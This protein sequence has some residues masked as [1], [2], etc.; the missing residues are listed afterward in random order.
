MSVA[1]IIS[2]IILVVYG[3]CMLLLFLYSLTILNLT[4][5][6]KQ[7]LKRKPV[8][9]EYAIGY[10]P[11]VTVQLPLYNEMYVVERLLHCIAKLDYPHHALQI[12]VLDDSTDESALHTSNIVAQLQ[13]QGIP[14]EYIHR[15]N[16]TGYK[17]GALKAGMA[18]AT[19]EFIAI[20]DADFL[21]QPNWIKKTIPYFVD[22]A[23]GVVQTRWGHINK[24]Y[25]LLTKI[26]AFALDSH[27][28]LEQVGRNAQQHYINFN[29]TAG[30]WRKACILDAGNWQADTLTEDLDLSYR[31][32]LRNW[33]FH[34]LVDVETPAELPTVLS[35]SRSQQFRWNKGGAENLVKMYSNIIKSK[36]TPTRTKLHG[37]MHLMNSSIFVFVFLMCI[38]SIPLLYIKHKYTSIGIYFNMLTFFLVSTFIFYYCY[39]QSYKYL[40]AKIKQ[41][42]LQY[43]WS[44]V[45]FYAVVLGFSFHNSMAVLE[46]WAGKKSAFIRTP[47]FNITTNSDDSWK[48]N[49]Y[50]S[51]SITPGVIVELLLLLYFIFGVVSSF[52]IQDFALLPFHLLLVIGYSFIVLQSFFRK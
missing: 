50:L 7:W 43:T 52:I 24:N 23:I 29:G 9:L 18:T 47:K 8:P 26:Q 12:Q 16:R 10:T 6:F 36:T 13:L 34:Y 30:I 33:K 22:D 28:T 38:L 40:Q 3:L 45:Q 14:I 41:S 48:R 25:S 32:Q 31:A 49:I 44:F 1:F 19:G 42:L 20:F 46:A 39:W 4:I 17:A 37:I 21:P 51:K 35:A 15:T 11:K 27:F 2:I 5:N